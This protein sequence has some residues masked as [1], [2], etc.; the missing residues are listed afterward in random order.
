[1][2]KTNKD[3]RFNR[4]EERRD[5]RRKLKQRKQ[6]FEHMDFDRLVRNVRVEDAE[7]IQEEMDRLGA[8]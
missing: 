4:D 5:N 8:N 2:S 6:S 3:L 1:M 7:R